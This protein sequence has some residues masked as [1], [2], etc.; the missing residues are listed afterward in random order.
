MRA[1]ALPLLLGL[2][3]LVGAG[4]PQAA[5]AAPQQRELTLLEFNAT[6]TVEEGG[7]LE[8]VE[9][10]RFRFDGSWN[11]VFRSIPVEMED[12]R[13]LRDRIRLDIR[14]I[15][16]GAGNRLEH[17]ISREGRNRKIK[18]WVPD[19]MDREE[20]V[21]IR[22]GVRNGLRFF[23]NH[24]ELYWNVTGNEWEIPIRR[25]VAR[26]VLP[27]GTT[28]RRTSFFTGAYGSVQ[29][30]GAVTEIEEGFLFETADLGFREGLSVVVGWDPGVVERPTALDR[31]LWI[32]SLNWPLLAPLLSLVLMW[33]L[34]LARGKDPE[35]RPIVPQYDPPEGL[36]PA[37]AGTLVDNTV[38]MRD[39]TATLVDL[40]V[41]GHLRIEEEEQGTFERLLS[42]PDYRFVRLHH[43]VSGLAPHERILL[44]ALF[45]EDD[46]VTTDDLENDFYREIPKIKK[47][48]YAELVEAGYYG[49]RPDSVQG[50]YVGIG[51][52]VGGIATAIFLFFANAAGAAPLA[53][54]IGG[55][56]AGIP[57]IGFGIVMPARTVRGARTM[58]QILG[59]EEFLTRVDSDRFRRMIKGPEQFEAFLPFAMAL[60]VDKQWA[61]AFERIYAEAAARSSGW[62]VGRN[63]STSFTP[64]HLV[65]DLSSVSSRTSSAMASAPRS[66]SSSSGFGGGGGFSGGGGGGG[67]GGG[68]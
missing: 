65:S 33:R 26:V 8:V 16:D 4:S 31:A 7:G 63:G 34:W 48:I 35:G 3:A 27:P 64:S 19:A 62:Y 30:E 32:L 20:T 37:A 55:I 61:G 15:V 38:D 10:L 11:G 12:S 53:A 28:G 17:E 50:A 9:A 6:L 1:A 2:T 54:I 25:A 40:A 57:V 56:G 60:S 29:S 47:A 49:R 36:S 58:E 42:K 41:R 68:F 22:Y 43:D 66:S 21:S 45:D 59:F 51:I 5:A 52:V 23:E 39:I 67:G 18:I 46:V 14:S 24:D 13:G 44:A